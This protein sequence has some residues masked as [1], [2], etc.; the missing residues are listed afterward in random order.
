MMMMCG[1]SQAARVKQ[2]E[3]A[4]QR[5]AASVAAASA[6][7]SYAI[8]AVADRLALVEGQLNEGLRENQ[9]VHSHNAEV[10]GQWWS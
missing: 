1:G 10:S 9:R 8:K 2:L 6:P 5:Q 3:E 4:V 7:S